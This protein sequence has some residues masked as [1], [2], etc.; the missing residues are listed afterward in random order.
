MFVAVGINED[1]MWTLP[2]NQH[3][4]SKQWCS[5]VGKSNSNTKIPEQPKQLA[6]YNPC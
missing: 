6:V 2:S 5:F 1:H 3:E 4:M